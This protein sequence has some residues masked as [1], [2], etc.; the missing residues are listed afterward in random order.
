MG[1]AENDFWVILK[2]WIFSIFDFSEICPFFAVFYEKPV[3]A[4]SVAQ[5]H[6]AQLIDG[7]DVA[8]KILRPNIHKRMSADIAVFIALARIM[9]FLAPRLKRLRLVIAVEQFK[10]LS[11]LELDMRIEAA[12][13]GKLRDNMASDNG[14]RVPWIEHSLTSENILVSEWISGPV[15][16]THLTL[17]TTPYV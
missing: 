12:A 9:E 10:Q 6:K 8:V 15:S 1:Y 11:E 17:P 5:V 2:I 14:I 7:R 16:Y 13:G 3:A 4:A